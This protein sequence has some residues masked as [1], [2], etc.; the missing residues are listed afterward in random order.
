MDLQLLKKQSNDL[1]FDLDMNTLSVIDA[2]IK[3]IKRG[4]KSESIFDF[5]R[6]NFKATDNQQIDTFYPTWLIRD[7]I[8]E[9]TG[10]DISSNKIS[11]IF[12]E[13]RMRRSFKNIK[14]FGQFSGF[15]CDIIH[16]ELKSELLSIKMKNYSKDEVLGKEEEEVKFDP[17]TGSPIYK[18]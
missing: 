9:K 11:R 12:S 17:L 2:N 1:F 14:G 7:F 5:I 18:D 16:N 13:M 6:D 10:A 8:C 15:H 4:A 3:R